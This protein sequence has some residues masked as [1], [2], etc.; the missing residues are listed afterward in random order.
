MKL[1]IPFISSCYL[2]LIVLLLIITI[3]KLHPKPAT[4]SNTT[5]YYEC[6]ETTKQCVSSSTQSPSSYPDLA[7][8]QSECGF[9]P[10]WGCEYIVSNDKSTATTG[11]CILYNVPGLGSFA[12]QQECLDSGQCK[13][14]QTIN[15][16][17]NGKCNVT[18]TGTNCPL[19]RTNPPSDLTAWTNCTST[20]KPPPIPPGKVCKSNSDCDASKCEV[21]YQGHCFNNC[22]SLNTT[23]CPNGDGTFNS[24]PPGANPGK[25]PGTWCQSTATGEYSTCPA[26]GLCADGTPCK[27]VACQN[28]DC[29]IC[30]DGKCQTS[31]LCNGGMQCQKP[32]GTLCVDYPNPTCQ[33]QPIVCPPGY[34]VHANLPPTYVCPTDPSL[35]GYFC[36]PTNKQCTCADGSQSVDCYSLPNSP[37]SCCACQPNN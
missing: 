35:N 24:C 18:C 17:T 6:N 11:N 32:D 25:C 20:C 30:L 7:T 2:F 14:P 10:M 23:Q 27:T 21:C 15:C 36:N 1:S 13:L 4:T 5:Y 3:W 8:C 19:P 37:Q 16:S 31:D 33:R 28:V 9:S 12:T 34:S 22:S 26:S 29:G